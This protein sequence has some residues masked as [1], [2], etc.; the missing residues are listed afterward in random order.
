MKKYMYALVLSLFASG[1]IAQGYRQR[2]LSAIDL[3]SYSDL[4]TCNSTKNTG[5]YTND[6]THL[7]YNYSTGEYYNNDPPARDIFYRLTITTKS[8][9]LYISNNGSSFTAGSVIYL[10]D[11]T[12]KELWY[13]RSY[14][15]NDRN[16][17]VYPVQPGTYYIVTEAITYEGSTNDI[18]LIKTSVEGKARRT[19]EDF[20][21]PAGLGTFSSN[22]TASHTIGP[23]D[24]RQ[25]KC[26]FKDGSELDA[27]SD[28]RDLVHQFTITKPMDISLDNIGSVRIE[29][30][31]TAYMKIISALGDTIREQSIDNFYY[32]NRKFNYELAAG[33]YTVYSKFTMGQYSDAKYVLNL[34]GKD[35]LPGSSPLS[36]IDI[37]SKQASFTYSQT[38]N[39]SLFS[40][41]KVVT[42]SGNEVF[43][44][45]TLTVPMEITVDNCGSAVADTYLQVQSEDKNQYYTND[46]Y[47]GSGACANT[48]NAYIKILALLPGTYYIVS[49]GAQNGNITTTIKGT[50]LGAMGDKLITAIDAGTHEVG[51]NFTDTKNTAS[52]FTNQFAGKL[53]NDVYYK[54]TLTD[55]MDITVSHCG[56]ATPDT[57]MSILNAGGTVV[58]TNDNYTGEGK[59]TN[60]G[61]AVIKVSKMPKGVY[62]V[63]SEGNSQNG[64][65]TT[66]IEGSSAYGNI[67]TTKG[68]PHVIT[69]TPTVEAG[70]LEILDA[71]QL[72]RNV[73]YFDY[74]GYPTVNIEL[75]VAPLGGD[76]VTLQETDG[77]FRKSK[78]W[79]PIA[80]NTNGGV[81]LTPEEIKQAAKITTTYGID[82]RPYSQTIY[83]GSPLDLVVEQFGPGN[84]WFSNGRSVKT[85]R[86]ANFG[87]SGILSCARYTLGGTYTAPTLIKTGYYADYELYVTRTTDEDNHVGYEFKDKAGRM[88]LSR[89]MNGATPHDTYYVYDDYGNLTFVIPPLASDILTATNTAWDEA[90]SAVKNYAYMY[91]YDGYNRCIFKKLPGAEPVYSIY[92]KADRLI[93]TQDGEQRAKPTPEWTFTIPDAFGRAAL[94]GRCVNSLNYLANPLGDILVKAEYTGG[95]NAS[96][97]YTVSGVTLANPI[98]LSANYYDNYAFLNTNGIN[99]GAYL[100]EAGFGTPYPGSKGLLTG[101]LIAQLEPGGAV[102]SDYLYSV[103][104]YDNRGRV[105][106]VAEKVTSGTSRL[107][108]NY[109]FAGNPLLVKERQSVH[110][111]QTD[112]Q[113]AYTYD[114]AGRRLSEKVSVNGVEQAAITYTHDEVGRLASQKYAK[115]TWSTTETMGYNI[116]SWLTEKASPYFSMQLRYN[117]VLLPAS[118]KNYGG[119]ISEWTWQHSGGTNNMYSLQYDDADRLTGARQYVASGSSWAS[120]PSHYSENGI[121][122]DKN[123]NIL[124]LQRSAGGNT[125]D[126]LTYNYDGNRLSALTESVASPGAADILIQGSSPQGTYNYNANG[127]MVYDSRKNSTYGYNILNLTDMVKQGQTVKATYKW[128]ATG[129]KL[130]VRDGTGTN[131]LDYAGS[132]VY[133]KSASGM[134][135]DAI[136]FDHG[137][138]R[139]QA[140]GYMVNYFLNDHLGS[141]R[142][143]VDGNGTLLERNDYYPFGARHKRNDYLAS[144]NRY[145]YNGKEEQVVGDVGFLDYGARMYDATIGRWNVVD[146]LAEKSRRYSFYVYGN[147]NPIRFI[148]PDGKAVI[149][150]NGGVT[151][152]GEDAKLAFAAYKRAN[153]NGDFKIHFVKEMDTPNIYRHTLNS[154]RLGKPQVLHYDSDKKR[155]TKRR[156]QA[157]QSYLPKPGMQRDEYP[158][159]STF[160]GGAGANVAYV[161]SIENSRQGQSLANLYSDM[162]Q[163]EAFLVLPVPKGKEPDASPDPV[164]VPFPV[165][166][167]R[168]T[169]KAVPSLLNRILMRVLPMPILNLPEYQQ[170]N[171][172][173]NNEG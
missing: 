169:P 122:Y 73:Q 60:T 2:M 38:Q 130:S 20:F 151:Y 157:T 75:D 35:L 66:T 47:T 170:V 147:D 90:T 106:Q 39:T 51:F 125:I 41:S 64:L 84:D 44:K 10:L 52:E 97:G 33:T 95:T 127:N 98:V 48:Q 45:L 132:V 29:S 40:R 86:W 55:S 100:P 4:F 58:Y 56:S 54:F 109:D 149:N 124:T 32:S 119:G 120:A 108:T 94:S 79:L 25:Y 153:E 115:G 155:R 88:L 126:N 15:Q 129:A 23:D 87:T 74:F 131:G 30:M 72:H 22:F 143:V 61:N 93:Y 8:M 70:N 165:P 140:D 135:V 18:G 26:D 77:L 154:F 68:Q 21:Y 63:V 166:V 137:V 9:D 85:D 103:K 31:S 81:F 50:T 1:T 42:K 96:M 78:G 28:R 24:I 117:N 150:I 158:Y 99:D 71:K 107:N 114:H 118:K 34:T 138:I 123:G 19:G 111:L 3:G 67:H 17:F 76:R 102:S 46:T 13:Y 116:R 152:T 172:D 121:S 160:E 89:R 142:V 145:K 164:P 161:P 91:K 136:H 112:I 37:G 173:N 156:Y 148:D 59:C 134:T 65:I 171:Q 69:L 163:G 7:E 113:T 5:D 104:Y 139:K 159:A 101:T 144:D 82:Q 83:D 49:D 12:G 16:S 57:Y 162:N 36:P 80:K 11:A 105:I 27:Y 141:T 128:S 92:D 43:Y 146:P 53:T 110:G 62:Y 6:Y 133:A 14:S 168:A 167:L